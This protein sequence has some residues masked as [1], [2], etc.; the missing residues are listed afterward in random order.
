MTAGARRSCPGYRKP[1]C[2]ASRPSTTTCWFGA[3]SATSVFAPAPPA[4][5]RPGDEHVDQI[6]STLGLELG[7]RSRDGS[8][9]LVETVC[10][11][12]CHSSPA[13]RDGET[14][15][16]GPGVITR[17]ADDATTDAPEPAWRS[18][19]A[20][21][22]LTEPGDLV[23]AAARADRARPRG[24]ARAGRGCQGPRPRRRRVPGRHQVAVHQAGGEPREVHRRQ[25]RRG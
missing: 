18:L 13:V 14:I 7:E 2:T 6:E 25:R 9:S 21:P 19:L 11:G 5:R 23:G 10:L 22:V 15:D 20:E 24:A 1:R 12:F 4:S 17:V 16:A 8:T 3:A